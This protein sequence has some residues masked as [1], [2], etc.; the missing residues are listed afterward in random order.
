MSEAQ[1]P[2]L[3]HSPDPVVLAFPL[4]QLHRTFLHS[5]SRTHHTSCHLPLC[6]WGPICW[7]SSPSSPTAFFTQQTLWV[8]LSFP[9]SL[10]SLLGFHGPLSIAPSLRTSWH[11]S[12]VGLSTHRTMTLTYCHE[13]LC[14]TREKKNPHKRTKEKKVGYV[15]GKGESGFRGISQKESKAEGELGLCVRLE[16]GTKKGLAHAA[17]HVQISGSVLTLIAVSSTF[18]LVLSLQ[19]AGFLSFLKH[20]LSPHPSPI[21]SCLAAT[22]QYCSG[23]PGNSNEELIVLG[24]GVHSWSN[25]QSHLGP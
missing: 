20:A 16:P 11:L 14:V 21:T 10:K 8:W 2:P 19:H 3:V 13:G 17:A 7:K 4:L 15:S 23:L 9:F 5:F 6:P 18:S 25:Q 24:S 12:R 1:I 22:D